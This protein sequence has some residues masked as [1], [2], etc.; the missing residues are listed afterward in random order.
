MTEREEVPEE[1]RRRMEINRATA[2]ARRQAKTAHNSF[3]FNELMALAPV[4]TD[5][6]HTVLNLPSSSHCGYS[7]SL[8]LHHHEKPNNDAQLHQ[9]KAIQV[10]LELTCRR[11]F[12]FRPQLISDNSEQQC[13]HQIPSSFSKFAESECSTCEA[14]GCTLYDLHCYDSMVKYLRSFSRIQVQ[15]IPWSTRVILQR[16][17][18]HSSEEWTPF[19]PRHL[20]QASVDDL[21]E[22]LP[23]KLKRSLLPFQMEGVRYGL[24]RGG[25]FL[26]A[27]EMGVGK[28]IQAIATAACYKEEGPL[29]VICPAS[30]RLVWAE[31]LERWLP[32]LSPNDLHLVFGRRNDLLDSTPPK[33]VIISYTML[34][35]LR[36]SMLAKNWEVVIVDES[37]NLRSS[38]RIQE[39]EEIRSVLQVAR[40]A[41]RAIFLSGTPSLSRPFD[42]FNQVDCLWPGLLGKN[43]Y[44]FARKYCSTEDKVKGQRTYRDY[45]KGNRLQ[46]LNVL[47]KETVMVRR[48][49]DQILSQLPPKRRQVIRLK[50]STI[51]I[52]DAKDLRCKHDEIVRKGRHIVAPQGELCRC[53]FTAKGT[54][55]CEEFS[56]ENTCDVFINAYKKPDSLK[57]NPQD[58]DVQEIG[59]AKLRG[60]REWLYNHPL[61]NYKSAPS[62]LKDTY[63]TE[64]IILFGHHQK[65]LNALQE[66]MHARGLDYIRIDG[67]TDAKDR[68]TA[69]EL[70]RCKVEVKVAIIGVTAGGVGLNLSSAQTVVFVELPKFASELLQ[71]EDRA[72]RRGQKGAVNVYIFCAKDTSDEAHWQSLSNS[73]ERVSTMTNGSSEALPGIEVFSVDDHSR[74]QHDGTKLDTAFPKELSAFENIEEF[75]CEHDNRD[76]AVARE[77]SRNKQLP[78]EFQKNER[79]KETTLVESSEIS[80]IFPI[81][82]ILTTSDLVSNIQ[83][84]SNTTLVSC[85]KEGDLKEVN[86]QEGITEKQSP[87]IWARDDLVES[88]QLVTDNIDASCESKVNLIKAGITDGITEAKQYSDVEIEP[89]TTG[90]DHHVHIPVESMM[91]Q[92]S[93]NTGRIHLYKASVGNCSSPVS[94]EENFRLEDLESFRLSHSAEDLDL[95]TCL[96]SST[97]H[98]DAALSFVKEWKSLR[99]IH[100][101]KLSGRPLSLPLT[102]ELNRLTHEFT[103]VEGGLIEGGSKR[104]VR[105][106]DELMFSLPE[107]AIWKTIVLKSLPGVQTVHTLQAWTIDGRPLC[108]LCQT[109]CEGSRSKF[110]KFMEDLFCKVSCFNEYQLKTSQRY[111]REELFKIERGVCVKCQLDCHGLVERIRFL[112]K[113]QRRVYTIEKA[114]QFEKHKNLL[115]KLIEDPT[116]GNA[117]HADHIV[118]VFEGG[119]ECNLENMR[120]LC[121][122]CHAKVTAEQQKRRRSLVIKAQRSLKFTMEKILVQRKKRQ[123]LN[124]SLNLQVTECNKD[125]DNSKV[126]RDSDTSDSDGELL[127]VAV[128]GSSYSNVTADALKI[129]IERRFLSDQEGYDI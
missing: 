129:S 26:L 81:S 119:G 114:P 2:I 96:I 61:F 109:P 23:C 5:P 15:Q 117:W 103:Y 104:R 35:R 67:N 118:P 84:V 102:N 48:L 33:V 69:I 73:L 74:P 90:P 43:K 80:E 18:K 123:K 112:P 32:F 38:K 101:K 24:Q 53:G 64:K 3:C 72:H 98:Q 47:L 42:I 125:L 76:Q 87:T 99:P 55:D 111:L 92:V 11:H 14:S 78:V 39:S 83:H 1:L 63:G 113:I 25:R 105:P 51:D 10:I 128:A 122:A 65:V 44:E 59:L 49:K 88:T 116:E 19:H 91:Y 54:C 97:Y 62:G 58:L 16:Y 60:V 108:K 20:P 107:G 41:K 68:H 56:D 22:R 27:D 94:L 75:Y 106:R 127:E 124:S 110:P 6:F 85:Q 121:V 29:L 70:F 120:T 86:I 12:T 45:S 8:Q 57:C 82:Q 52:L 37:H 28:T 115:E 46:E 4:K 40:K 77:F 126:D 89:S 30:L 17:F 7:E 93:S 13:L 31:E 36:G 9:A 21:L 50:L 66:F 71:A 34:N 95:P 100:R 79:D